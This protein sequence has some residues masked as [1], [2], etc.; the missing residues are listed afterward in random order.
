[1]SAMVLITE[2]ESVALIEQATDGRT[3]PLAWGVG[4]RVALIS[5]GSGEALWAL[6]ALA[7]MRGVDLT[8][9]EEKQP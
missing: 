5:D 1:M 6:Y 2:E 4:G 9:R 8:P 7:Q 3:L